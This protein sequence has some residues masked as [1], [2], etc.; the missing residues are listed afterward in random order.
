MSDSDASSPL[1]EPGRIARRDAGG[2]QAGWSRWLPGLRT[3]R[4]YRLA[5]FRHDL[6]AGLV[7]TTMLVPVGIA[8]AV[9]S[10]V[11]G[12]YGLYATII[13]LLAYA[14]FGPSR[15]LVLGPDSSLAAV[16]LAVVLPLSGGDPQ[17][18]IA[19]AGAMAIVSG[20]V[21]VL[22]GIARLGFVTELLS[23]PIRYGYMNGI[24]L[25]VLISQLPK[26]FGFKIESEG[27]LR[28]LW[29][30]VTSIMDGKTNW[31]TFAV[32]AATLVVILLLKG[33]KRIPGILIAVVAATLAVAALDLASAGV[34]VLGSLPQ[35]L[36]GFA[37]PWI[38][39]ADIVPVLL[40]GCAVALVSFAD[41]SVLSRVYAARTRTYVDPNQEM[42]GLG[43][44]NLAAGF[45]QGF[46]ISSSS[47]RTPVAEAA[48]AKTQ[49]TG[50]VGAVAVALLLVLAPDLLRDLPNSALA[51]VVIASAIGLIEITD[52][53]R[54]Y[55]IQRWE[56]WL[57]IVC[58]VGVAVL[59]AIEGI[60][61]A[62][63]IAVIEFLWD[64]WRPYSAVL[65]QAQGVKGFH[66]TQRYPDARLIPGLVLFRWDA[67]LFFAN[68]E[69]FHD[70]VI[71]ALAASPTPVRWLVI[72]AE[73]IT[74]VD[75][76][77]ADMLA[78]LDETLRA[79]GITLCVAEMKDPVKDKL[80][81]FGLYSLL[82][83]GAFFPTIDD[84]VGSYLQSHPVGG[85]AEGR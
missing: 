18:A 31:I 13:P 69:L 62:I 80:K 74:S 4:G 22:A 66:D 35:G 71:D 25:T 15:I 61:L 21:C 83:E 81:R 23:K 39:Q 26:L 29:A 10:G 5:W 28:N 46:A 8:Y 27:P 16:I 34:S 75:V 42:V 50:V 51:A 57:S 17:R 56:F 40:G 24:A 30:I 59:G 20:A 48:G 7:L 3:L 82:G 70:R 44:A 9:A 12:I 63:L 47:S 36:P 54:I 60:G 33:H 43:V 41:T 32:G 85:E 52:L 53:K 19:L 38:T 6:V 76:T 79:A 65:G 49:M 73:P 64:G 67:S 45:F 1:P 78:E 37:I 55:R 84:A 72:A 77:S 68:A 58:T 14:L 2:D 11:P